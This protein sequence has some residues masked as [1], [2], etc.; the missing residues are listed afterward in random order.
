VSR[1]PVGAIAERIQAFR[2]QELT[3]TDFVRVDGTHDALAALDDDRL[4]G[5]VDLDDPSELLR[6]RLRPSGVAT[7]DR[8]VTQ[9]IA[10]TLFDEGHS[11]FSWWSTLEAS[12]T[13]VTLFAERATS[14]LKVAEELMSIG[15]PEDKIQVI[16]NGVDLAEFRPG[17]A[18]REA[19]G[20]PSDRVIA[21]FVGDLR[22]SIK[23]LDTILQSLL[24]VPDAYLVVVGAANGSKYTS[25]LE[26]MGLRKRVCF[27]G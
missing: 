24:Q 13:N 20:L 3:A 14:R 1:T 25:F 15:V 26:K 17:Y 10:L 7:R 27:I 9:R 18:E 4:E 16:P 11:G 22:S 12:W 8:A 5:L 2:G 19:V 21:L 23:N 6:R